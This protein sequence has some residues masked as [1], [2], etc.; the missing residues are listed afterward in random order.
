M[1]NEELEFRAAKMR[2]RAAE[3]FGKNWVGARLTPAQRKKGLEKIHAANRERGKALRNNV[4][5]ITVTEPAQRLKNVTKL[6]ENLPYPKC[7]HCTESAGT[8]RA[9]FAHGIQRYRCITCRGTYSGPKIV[10]KLEPCDYDLI[11]YH[12]GSKD[13]SRIGKGMS[14]SRTGRM[15][16]CHACGRKFVQGGLFELQRCHLLLEDRIAKSNLPEDVEAEVLQMAYVDI[17]EG[18]GYTWSVE[19]RIKEAWRNARG[20]YAQM[21]SDHPKFKLQMGQNPY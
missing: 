3:M 10:I 7:T 8:I 1:W 5:E 19:L 15:A 6:P 16:I 13:S 11:C 21:G 20:E 17:L 18:K 4:V 2:Q 14:K 9:G 12:C